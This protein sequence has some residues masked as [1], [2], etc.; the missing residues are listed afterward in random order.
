MTYKLRCV[1][2]TLAQIVVSNVFVNKFF[3]GMLAALV[4]PHRI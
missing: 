4:R 3:W 1:I 2:S